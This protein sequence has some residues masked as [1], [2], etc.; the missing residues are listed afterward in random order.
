MTKEVTRIL[1]NLSSTVFTPV[2]LQSSAKEFILSV[3]KMAE[4]KTIE[5][6][7]EVGKYCLENKIKV[8]CEGY[9]KGTN[10]NGEPIYIPKTKSAMYDATF[11]N[12]D[13]WFIG[14][15]TEL[16]IKPEVISADYVSE[17]KKKRNPNPLVFAQACQELLPC[18]DY[19]HAVK[20]LNN[21]VKGINTLWARILNKEKSNSSC[22]Y[23]YSTIGG[24]GK[25]QFSLFI[26]HWAKKHG[27]ACANASVPNNQFIGREFG[28]NLIVI[29]EEVKLDQVKDF[30]YLNKIIDGNSYMMELK[31][32]DKVAMP[33][34]CFVVLCSNYTPNDANSRRIADSI[35]YFGDTRV[36]IKNPAHSQ[37]CF[38]RLEDGEFNYDYYDEVFERLILSCPPSNFAYDKYSHAVPYQLS[39][40]ES[41]MDN[42]FQINTLQ[43]I[44][45]YLNS[46]YETYRSFKKI[47]SQTLF[48]RLSHFASDGRGTVNSNDDF[49]AVS[50][51]DITKGGVHKVLSL[52]SQKNLIRVV[53][54]KDKYGKEFDLTK[55]EENVNSILHNSSYDVT[56]EN[57]DGVIMEKKT[58]D[59][60]C[61]EIEKEMEQT[62]T[63]S[64]PI[65][66]SPEPSKD[67]EE[68]SIE[69][70]VD[71]IAVELKRVTY[72]DKFSTNPHFNNSSDP[73]MLNGR[74]KDEYKKHCV[75]S[76]QEETISRRAENVVP[77]YFVFECDT[78]S[79]EEQLDFINSWNEELRQYIKCITFS[80]NRS[81]HV[82]F[83]I[84]TPEDITSSEY[85]ELWNKFMKE[86]KL[87]EYADSA[88]GSLVRLTRNPNGVRED[89]TVQKCIYFNKDNKAID[90]TADLEYMRKK[91]KEAEEFDAKF[92]GLINSYGKH[93]SDN[94]KKE[95]R[96]VEEVLE[97]IKKDCC[98]KQ[99]WE[100]IKNNDFP[101]GTDFLAPA[102]G[103]FY[104][105]CDHG[106]TEDE[107][108]EW[109]RNNYLMRVAE[110]HPSNISVSSAKRWTAPKR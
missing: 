21:M 77:E 9:K 13:T 89:G 108:T 102:R 110:A 96:P 49:D 95:K 87:D 15:A 85:K 72:S 66:P 106:Y 18:L 43:A 14:I 65:T 33:V 58:I 40:W 90:L 11:K 53:S 63:P 100:M 71:W 37:F 27:A 54:N 88:C 84:K 98:A 68:K 17:L 67:K 82:L 19:T 69:S 34:T 2:T 61:A 24:V 73:Y 39:E 101:S 31:G 45:L 75:E 52:L 76:G 83:S 51:E 30:S 5:E 20:N 47:S 56:E 36:D 70:D 64:S 60:I 94:Y 91:R 57:A 79:L 16:G 62:A 59:A 107:A 44:A 105:L 103:M 6:V 29:D 4:V 38:K 55:L 81:Y 93:Y 109:V 28:E 10:E 46:T 23:L 78:K 42:D 104:I 26:K 1:E 25:S 50:F 22:L 92:K 41:A 12:C 35:I 99:G 7:V 32:K 86:N 97:S 3:C 8:C 74:F 80:G 48:N